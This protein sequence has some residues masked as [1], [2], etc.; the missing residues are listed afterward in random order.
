M[1]IPLARQNKC[2]MVACEAREAVSD[3]MA[4]RASHAR[5][6]QGRIPSLTR[7]RKVALETPDA[8]IARDEIK[9]SI[10]AGEATEYREPRCKQ[11]CEPEQEPREK[12]QSATAS[13]VR[14]RRLVR[15]LGH[16]RL[17]PAH[18]TWKPQPLT[19]QENR[20]KEPGGLGPAS[21]RECCWGWGSRS[22]SS[23]MPRHLCLLLTWMDR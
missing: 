6:K 12:K 1:T 17:N 15:T 2:S 14:H 21:F 7:H 22:S 8:K 4:S 20:K 10:I 19:H 5:W 18:T 11:S 9:Q 23:G 13:P 16:P 3:I